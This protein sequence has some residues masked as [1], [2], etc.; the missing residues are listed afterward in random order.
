MIVPDAAA[1]VF[2][3]DFLERVDLPVAELAEQGSG[4]GQ[5]ADLFEEG[6]D[7]LISAPSS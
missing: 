2:E 5:A 7:V 3:D 6:G 1:V 4:G